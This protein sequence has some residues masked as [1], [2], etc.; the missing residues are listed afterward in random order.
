[1]SGDALLTRLEA[2]G[3]ENLWVVYHDYGGR[4]CAKTVPREKFA[5]VAERGVVFARANLSM[6][7]DDHQSEG[8]TFL[9]DTGDFLAVPDAGSYARV[10]YRPAT[11]RA[12]AHLRADD[13]SPWAGCPRTRLERMVGAYAER[14]LSVRAGFEPEF[15]LFRRGEDGGYAPA[16]HDGMFT[17]RGLDRHYALWRSVIDDL[18]EMGIVVEQLGKEYGPAQYEGTTRHAEPVSA[19]DEYLTLKE[20]VRARAREAGCVASFMPKPFEHLPG[21]GL[22]VHLSLWDAAGDTEL[23]CGAGDGEALSEL[24]RRMSAGL[25]AH[26]RGLC[27]VGSPIVNSYK[28]LQPGSWAPAHV[29]WGIGNRAALVRVPGSGPRRHL[30]YRSGDGAANPFLF[31]TALLAAGLDGIERGLEAPAPIDF[32]VGHLSAAE[33]EARGIALLPRSLPEALDAFEADEVL[34]EALGPVIGSEHLTV[35]RSEL[36]AYDLHVHPWERQVYLEQL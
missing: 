9:A 11:A 8:A 2:D 19:V 33:T 12:H 13:G 1:M 30:E 4:S 16:D 21:C 32:D 27:G 25:L 10:P 29:C 34:R 20:V 24:G 31:L 15:I 18:R 26:A 23:S 7:M 5:A 35:K 28:R 14:G 17:V 36:S 22:H 3:V 6:R